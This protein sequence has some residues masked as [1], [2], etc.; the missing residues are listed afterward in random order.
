LA[1]AVAE[2]ILSFNRRIGFPTTLTEI[3]EINEAV[4]EKI[5][6]AA[7]DPQLESKLQNMPFPLTV[8]LVDQDLGPVLEAASSG[9]PTIIAYREKI[10]LP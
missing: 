1:Q 10:Q 7:R 9:D 3:E 8:D 6:I 4:I 2:G 5:L